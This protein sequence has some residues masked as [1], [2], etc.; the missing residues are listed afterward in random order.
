MNAGH[1][2]IGILAALLLAGAA[3]S[4]TPKE[5]M[6]TWRILEKLLAQDDVLP[7]HP[8]EAIRKPIP[9]ERT[10]LFDE[11]LAL[12]PEALLRGAAYVALR[13]PAPSNAD[14]AT[15]AAHGRRVNE[16]LQAVFEYYPLIAT[17]TEDFRL[18]ADAIRS[19]K[20]PLALRRFLLRQCAPTNR[21][22]T[23]LGRY[24]QDHLADGAPPLQDDLM[25]LVQNPTE[26]GELQGIAIP[27]LNTLVSDG[28]A[29]ILA[30][31]KEAAAH[32]KKTDARVEIRA[33]LDAPDTIP[34]EKKSRVRLE[35][36]RQRAGVIAGVLASIMRD[37]SRSPTLR[38]L[39]ESAA[40]ELAQ[41]YPLP[42]PMELP[43]PPPPVPAPLEN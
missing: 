22:S 33:V 3:G 41:A 10:F 40:T 19:G 15:R 37:E 29:W 28:F 30:Q 9:T 13:N 12:E 27:L 5:R 7:E 31:D 42:A 32:A 16:E 18:L 20:Q 26:D 1:G 25:A 34:L 14:E 21:M 8:G 39:A 24:L 11:V 38:A 2:W 6:P 35:Q 23:S 4:E 17:S 43:P 36:Q